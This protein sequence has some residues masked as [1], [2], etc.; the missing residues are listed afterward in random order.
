[1]KYTVEFYD[2]ADL[3]YSTTEA[4]VSFG[5]NQ[6]TGTT[7]YST[8]PRRVNL[9]LFETD[10]L[11][12]RLLIDVGIG[13][14]I[15]KFT[16]KISNETERIF[17][18]YIDLGSIG[19]DAKTMIY[20]L[21]SYDAIWVLNKFTDLRAGMTNTDGIA[22]DVI[23]A[24]FFESINRELINPIT[25]GYDNQA[26]FDISNKYLGE[27]FNL[28][29]FNPDEFLE[30]LLDDAPNVGTDY[31]QGVDQRIPTN[32]KIRFCETTAEVEGVDNPKQPLLMILGRMKQL[33]VSTDSGI[34]EV[35]QY[36]VRAEFYQ[37]Y[38][39]SGWK[40]R[41][42]L[43]QTHKYEFVVA[44]GSIETAQAASLNK[45]DSIIYQ[46]SANSYAY[47]NAIGSHEYTWE[48]TDPQEPDFSLEPTG[49]K[50]GG[51]VSIFS[52]TKDPTLT[53]D[54]TV[55]EEI[56]YY[57]PKTAMQAMLLYYDYSLY[58][59]ENGDIILVNKVNTDAT[60]ISIIRADYEEYK[61]FRYKELSNS[62]S[63]INPLY[64]E[65]AGTILLHQNLNTE[66]IDSISGITAIITNT[67]YDLDIGKVI[68][69]PISN[70]DFAIYEFIY[71]EL[72]ERFIIKAWRK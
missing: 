65:Q 32:G 5:K 58:C 27:W 22:P 13:R 34:G 30:R 60:P 4:V 69:D 17:T 10:F 51:V 72:N 7:Y 55:E 43:Q 70:Q 9:S 14:G 18:G 25:F 40:E 11:K 36:A 52:R 54:Y 3:E 24:S 2:R 56:K 44:T 20:T 67:G 68:S 8:T 49:I 42:D 35:Y 39:V 62:L 38:N 6:L 63:G 50:L 48:V 15:S 19:Y 71:D 59:D 33:I 53:F 37:Y 29:T 23:M 66:S 46:Y 64:G 47:Y 12:Y 31:V 21:T 61:V 1:M 45:Y 57:N 16:V 41:K 28:N 26:S